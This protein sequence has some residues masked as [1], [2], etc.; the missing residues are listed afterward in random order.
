MFTS[1]STLTHKNH[2]LLFFYIVVNSPLDNMVQYAIHKEYF[3]L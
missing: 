2:I 3:G 1:L